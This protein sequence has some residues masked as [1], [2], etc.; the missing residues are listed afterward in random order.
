MKL[1]SMMAT[2][3]ATLLLSTSANALFIDLEGQTADGADF[4]IFTVN[5]ADS[6][7]VIDMSFEF[8]YD[9]GDNGA[10]ISWGSELVVEVGHLDSGTFAQIG[11]EAGGCAS[12][13]VACEFDLMWDDTSGTFTA[14]GNVTFLDPIADGSGD[15]QIL[16]ADSFD[17]AGIDGRFL[18]GSFIEINQVQVPVPATLLLIGLGVAGMGVARRRA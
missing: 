9:A 10:N 3:A 5:N 15:W 13:G 18:A 1:K 11:T 7:E 12:F 2:A 17:D 8:V 6:S 16:I 14:M 4:N